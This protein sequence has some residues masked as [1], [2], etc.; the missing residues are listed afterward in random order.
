M[1]MGKSRNI[2]TKATADSMAVTVS[3]RTWSR[4]PVRTAF[5]SLF[6]C[7]VITSR[8]AFGPHQKMV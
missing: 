6:A 2:S 8:G 1:G 5:A 3:L 7:M 4:P